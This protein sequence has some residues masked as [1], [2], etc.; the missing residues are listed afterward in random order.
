MLMVV[1]WALGLE[2]GFGGVL[3]NDTGFYLSG[4]SDYIQSSSDI[5]H[6]IYRGLLLSKD[7]NI[8]DLVCYSDSLHCINLIQGSLHEVP[9]QCGFDSRYKEVNS[10]DKCH[11]TR[12]NITRGG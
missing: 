11:I 7:M 6:A 5:L 2:V 10:A 12:G 1:V 3:R 4:F 8:I 9:C